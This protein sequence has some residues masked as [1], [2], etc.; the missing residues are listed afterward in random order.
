MREYVRPWKLATLA[1]GV[2]LLIAGSFYYDAP[3]WDVPISLLMAGLTYLTAPWSLRVLVERKWKRIPAM[4]IATWFTVDGVYWIYWSFKNP[5]AVAMMRDANFTASLC[6][7][8]ICGV[9][10][11]YRGSLK[12]MASDAAGLVNRRR[13]N[14]RR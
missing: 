10:W 9:L 11:L 6:L 3:D 8:G 14:S 13:E 5:T 12:Q 2:S 7:Y 4:L 1:M